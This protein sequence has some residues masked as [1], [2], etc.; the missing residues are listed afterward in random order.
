MSTE[1]IQAMMT[2]VDRGDGVAL[3]KLYEQNG[4]ALHLQ[5]P[6]S[7]TASSELMSMLGLAN[8]EKD[9]LIS[10]G[11]ESLVDA[12]L[13]KLSDDFRGI[14]SVRGITFSLPLN[15]ISG[16]LAAAIARPDFPTIEGGSA[17]PSDKEHSLIFV[18]INQGY[19]DPVMQTAC[20]AGAT[21]GTVI[22]GRW[23]GAQHLE[24]FHGVTLQDEKEILMIACAK[25]NRN[26]IME[27]VTRSH[28]VQKPA[29][30]VLCAL[31]I[32][33]MVRLS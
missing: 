33:R 32:D 6:A 31:P 12:L 2:I 29:Q 14:L 15:A 1:R 4:V 23:V 19:S 5:M 24:Q 26:D 9:F 28:G 17:M 30:A 20:K 25:E 11:P 27:A 10:F 3:S 16:F 13:D 21:G 7:G 8:R 22:R 18:F